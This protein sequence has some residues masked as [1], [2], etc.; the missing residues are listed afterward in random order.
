VEDEGLAAPSF[1][2]LTRVA[3]VCEFFWLDLTRVMLQDLVDDKEK[4]EGGLFKVINL[5][6]PAIFSWPQFTSE[7]IKKL[8]LPQTTRHEI[9]AIHHITC[10]SN[11]TALAKSPPTKQLTTARRLCTKQ[12]ITARRLCTKQLTT[13]RRLCTKQLITARRLCTKQLTT[14]RR[15]CTKQLITARRLCT[16]AGAIAPWQPSACVSSRKNMQ[17]HAGSPQR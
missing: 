9:T 5:N 2:F 10:S 4:A 3:P 17:W 6:L 16:R 13:A 8:N 15:L 11:P 1:E 14:A 7:Y 12:L